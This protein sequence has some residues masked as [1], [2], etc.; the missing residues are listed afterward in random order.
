MKKTATLLAIILPYQSVVAS[1]IGP[2]NLHDTGQ[3][4]NIHL[5]ISLAVITILMTVCSILN[6]KSNILKQRLKISSQKLSALSEKITCLSRHSI[7]IENE[8]SDLLSDMS[9]KEQIAMVTPKLY[10]ESGEGKFRNRFILL[11]PDFIKKLREAVPDV[12]RSEEIL[13]M[14]I[15]LDQS[16]EQMIDILCISRNSINMTRHRLR[17]K[18]HLDRNDALE[19]KIKELLPEDS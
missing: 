10:R 12:T 2:Y 4:I 11:Y 5:I 18:M 13:C 9:N 6:Y 7:E 19:E 16:T 14:L 1:I 3:F 17:R 15:I 8:L